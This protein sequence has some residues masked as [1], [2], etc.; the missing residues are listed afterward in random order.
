MGEAESGGG[1]KKRRS[2]SLKRNRQKRKKAKRSFA[3][4]PGRLSPPNSCRCPPGETQASPASQLLLPCPE[5]QQVSFSLPQETISRQQNKWKTIEDQRGERKLEKL[6][7]GFI[8]TGVGGGSIQKNDRY[9]EM[10]RI[11][12]SYGKPSYRAGENRFLGYCRKCVGA[13]VRSKPYLSTSFC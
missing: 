6:K 9:E 1:E 11:F 5:A 10:A 7:R 4:G 8:G 12:G 3:R 13:T 2:Q